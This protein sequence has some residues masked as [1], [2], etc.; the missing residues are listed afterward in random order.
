M[1]ENLP[2]A[3]REKANELLGQLTPAAREALLIK[4]W[5]SHDARWFV[6]VSKEYG[7]KVANRLNQTAAHEI[8]KVEAQRIMRALDRPPVKSL[9]D[10]L[11]VQGLFIS[12]K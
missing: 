11:L 1:V 12:Q 9:D 2:I 4:C 8:G 6:A 10:Y 7:M 3:A 5:M